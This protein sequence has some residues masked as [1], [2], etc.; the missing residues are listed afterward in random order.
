MEKFRDRAVAASLKRQVG[1]A[2]DE[3]QALI[4]RPRGRGLI[5]AS[6]LGLHPQ[7]RTEFRDRAVAA[8]L[9]P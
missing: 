9:K 5:E 6:L 8:S 2:E 1:W 7:S 3:P 4:P